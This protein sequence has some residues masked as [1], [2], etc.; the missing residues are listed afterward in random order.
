MSMDHLRTLP[1]MVRYPSSVAVP[2]RR[3]DRTM[4]GMKFSDFLRSR[5]D[6]I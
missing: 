2:L 5:H 3:V 4:N 6:C 1:I